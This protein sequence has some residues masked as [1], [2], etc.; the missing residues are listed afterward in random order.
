MDGAVGVRC[1]M[2]HRS[3]EGDHG[4]QKSQTVPGDHPIAA[5]RHRAWSTNGVWIPFYDILDYHR[6]GG[7]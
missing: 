2:M 5:P 4:D 3:V 1:E 6:K 7:E